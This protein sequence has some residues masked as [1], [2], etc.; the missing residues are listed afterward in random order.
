[1]KTTCKRILSIGAVAILTIGFTFSTSH[2]FLQA[3]LDKLKNTGS[4]TGCD[5]SSATLGT[6]NIIPY[7]STK[8]LS[9]A[10]FSAAVLSN[11]NLSNALCTG[12]NFKNANLSRATLNGVTFRN[13]DLS[14]ANMSNAVMNGATYFNGANLTAATLP[15]NLNK[16]NFSGAKWVDGVRTCKTPSYGVCN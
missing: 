13:A 1:M 8:D 5:L 14:G 3:H 16:A 10:N 2:A 6:F 12:A 4:C 15:A 11:A 7:T 9:N